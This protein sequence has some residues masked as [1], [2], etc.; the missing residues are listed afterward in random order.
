MS[1]RLLVAD[2]S[3]VPIQDQEHTPIG[4]CFSIFDATPSADL[5]R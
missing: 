4:I 5:A 1:Y 3:Y 2:Y